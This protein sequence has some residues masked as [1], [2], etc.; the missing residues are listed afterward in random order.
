[1]RR[2]YLLE[3]TVLL[4]VCFFS[5]RSCITEKKAN[6]DLKSENSAISDSTELYK[7]KY[8]QERAEKQALLDTMPPSADSF[9]QVLKAF[10]SRLEQVQAIQEDIH[11][12]ADTFRAGNKAVIHFSCG[13]R[14]LTASGLLVLVFTP[15]STA[16]RNE[17]IAADMLHPIPTVCSSCHKNQN[18]N[19]LYGCMD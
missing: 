12:Q 10:Y 9:A 6:T 1:M 8:G 13:N 17:F 4:I 19:C 18:S 15:K 14:W 11:L 2:S 5:V 7:E 16:L 3:Y